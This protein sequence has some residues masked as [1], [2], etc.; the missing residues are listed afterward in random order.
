MAVEF[1]HLH[2]HTDYSLLDGACNIKNLAKYAADLKMKACAITDHGNLGGAIVFV[3]S[4]KDNGIKPIIGSEFYL[5][6]TS[7]FDKDDKITNH[8]GYHL[9]ILAKN[10]EGFRN[11]SLLSTKSFTEG[12]YYNPRIDKE[13]LKELKGGLIGMS[14]CIAGEI[15]TMI[16]E[17]RKKEAKK[18][19]ES[20]LEIFGEEDF[21]LELMDN[22][23]KDQ[24]L[25]NKELL[26]LSKE[27]GLKVVATNDVHYIK[28]SH[29]KAQDVLV[30]ISTNKLLKDTNRMKFESEEMYLK[31]ADEMFSLF[32]DIPDAIK[33]TIE[34]AEKCNLELPFGEN[35]YPVF[36]ASGIDDKKKFLRDICLEGIK[37]KYGFDPNKSSLSPEEQKVID[38]MDYE[39]NVIAKAG[40]TS[41]FLIVWDFIKYAKSVNIPVGEG[42]G[43]GAGSI[44]AYLSGITGIDP[45]RFN[46]L[47]E[48]FL[49]PERVTPPD[50]DIDFCERRRGEVIDYVKN[51]YGEKSVVQV[52]TYNKMKEKMVFKDIARVLD[53]EASE[54][55]NVTKFFT[56]VDKSKLKSDDDDDEPPVAIEYIFNTIPELKKMKE[57]KTW[58]RE[59]LEY[60]NALEGLN[61]NSSVHAAA[62]IIGD[63]P[64]ENLVPLMKDKNNKILTQFTAPECESLGLLKMDFLGLS[65]LTIIQD[66]LDLVKQTKGISLKQEDIPLDDKK[67]YDMLNRGETACV[68]QL[69]SEGM[70]DTLMKFGCQR[71]EDIIDVIAIFRPGPMNFI[72]DYIAGKHGHKK[73][74]YDHPLIEPIA[75]DTFGIL[76]YQEQVI[77]SV[78]ALAGFSPGQADILRH[79]IGKKKHDLME[80]QKDKFI[81]GCKRT[82]NIPEEKAQQIWSKILSFAEYGFNKSHSAAYAFPAYRTAYLKANFPVEFMCANLTNKMNKRDDM[83][84]ILNE[85]RRIRIKVLPPDV[86]ISGINFT[87]DGNNIRF[88][89]GAVKSLGSVAAEAIKRTREKDGKFKDFLDF[90]IRAGDSINSRTL[91]N[92]CKAGAFDSF[93]IKRKELVEKIPEALKLADAFRKSKSEASLFD[94]IP[95]F[96][97]TITEIKFNSEQSEYSEKEL[98]AAEKE[99]LGFYVIGH[100]LGEQKDII[101]KYSTTNT[102]D[103]LAITQNDSPI[104]LGGI[105][106]SIERKKTKKTNKTYAIIEFEDFLGSIRC[107]IYNDIY[108]KLMSKESSSNPIL[109]EGKVCFIN[110]VVKNSND[111]DKKDFY[112][113]D[114]LEVDET[115]NKYTEEIHLR[116]FEGSTTEENINKCISIATENPGKTPIIICA[117]M[118]NGVNVFIESNKKVNA[119][120]EL[121]KT[122]ESIL[123]TNGIHIRVNKS[124]DDITFRKEP[125]F[126][127]KNYEKESND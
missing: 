56:K 72:P 18:A 37:E 119:S 30:C 19:I 81:E 34:I 62:V 115:V 43:S 102:K 63:Q 92:L 105:I 4:M 14:A 51:K 3:N 70:T 65:T 120:I 98:L 127:K 13:L 125:N 109:Q 52:A 57:E 23:Y 45:L 25:V 5:A 97:D 114:V 94:D 121:L 111:G 83:I 29:A 31:S 96:N 117:V 47:F 89:L 122:F 22:G 107:F 7:R 99:I 116:F 106:N 68:F 126:R 110:A 24:K 50:F 48:R 61:R 35:H 90:C 79:A 16:I 80:K 33:N 88:G 76:L 26:L 66:T 91:E 60:A 53:I 123:G 39:L 41:Y 15:P 77:Q 73:V 108:E 87:V 2:L 69:E 118:S 100:P 59:V 6:P 28:R 85:C 58:I 12:F 11:I 71:I 95:E 55:N 86:N 17:G 1:V 78:Q 36:N 44:V 54:A 49:N 103:A 27:Y 67:T 10:L 64:I 20:Y 38:R 75:K 84:N 32:K 46:L 8:R 21:Y 82:N 101:V 104:R 42:R 74:V 9:I 93:G 113:Y 40:Y 112:V 124:F